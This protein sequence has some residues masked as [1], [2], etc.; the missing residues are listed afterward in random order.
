MTGE[1]TGRIGGPAAR[2]GGPADEPAAAGY[3]MPMPPSE[4]TT[5][6]VTPRARSE[7]RNT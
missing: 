7:A 5:V 4:C 1:I 3:L 6:P 2:P